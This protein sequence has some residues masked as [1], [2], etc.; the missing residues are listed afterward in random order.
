MGP[1]EVDE[2]LS[3]VGLG[4][5]WE[6]LDEVVDS[7]R[8][9]RALPVDFF[10]VSPENYMRRGGY[11]PASLEEVAAR[12]PLLTHGLTLSLG[13]VDPLGDDYLT[14]LRRFLERFAPPFHSDHL[15]FQGAEERMVH[16]LLPLPFLEEAV[17][18][19]SARVRE[20]Q[21]RLGLPVVVENISYYLEPG[22]REMQEAEFIT[23]V[24]DASGARLLLDVNNVYVNSL[25]HGFDAREFLDALPL[26]R[27]AQIHVAGHQ[28][29]AEHELVIDTHGADIVDPVYAL[30]AHAL[31]RTGP[32][33]VLL[34][35]DHAIPPL[36]ALLAEVAQVRAVYDR[37]VAK[38]RAR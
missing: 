6:F 16:D 26:D 25:N 23:R 3:G 1:L 17:A 24:L 22:A 38:G 20:A 35:R 29:S 37:A 11:V 5:R 9:G 15:C 2:R 10:E 31:E 33:P 18:N 32:V 36:D 30:L 27:V 8:E 12:Y 4:L 19:T 7:A 14:E 13:G 28:R 21:D 34:E